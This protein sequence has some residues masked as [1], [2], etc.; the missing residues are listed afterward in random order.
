MR[1]SYHV[2]TSFISDRSFIHIRT[3]Y[4]SMIFVLDRSENPFTVI[5]NDVI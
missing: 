4:F 1:G 3:I 5:H 2:I